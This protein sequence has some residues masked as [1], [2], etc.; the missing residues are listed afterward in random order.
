M[1]CLVSKTTGIW[2]WALLIDLIGYSAQEGRDLEIHKQRISSHTSMSLKKGFSVSLCRTRSGIKFQNKYIENFL[3][4]HIFVISDGKLKKAGLLNEI[5]FSEQGLP[6]H[7]NQKSFC[8]GQPPSS[9]NGK[10]FINI[11]DWGC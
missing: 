3:L 7:P 1:I 9:Q 2:D 8:I 5:Y 6:I 4:H 10:S 11:P